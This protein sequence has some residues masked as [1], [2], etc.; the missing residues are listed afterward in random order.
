MSDWI[1]R[2]FSPQITKPCKTQ[3]TAGYPSCLMKKAVI[4][5]SAE[6]EALKASISKGYAG[7][8]G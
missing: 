2:E 4:L 3:F 8:A 5:A 7:K 6:L 1:R